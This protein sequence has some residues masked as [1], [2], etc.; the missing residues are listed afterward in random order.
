MDDPGH[1]SQGEPGLAALGWGPDLAG[2]FAALAGDGTVPARV[3]AVD[4]G[5]YLDFWQRVWGWRADGRAVV[6]VTHLLSQL[7]RVD[8]VIDLT[9]KGLA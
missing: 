8:A 3:V 7:D 6:V 9:P 1:T 4:R 5:S 2:A